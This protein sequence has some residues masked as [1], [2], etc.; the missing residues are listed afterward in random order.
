VNITSRRRLTITTDEKLERAREARAAA[1]ARRSAEVER[2]ELK[3]IRRVWD[4]IPA[5]K[6]RVF[7][8]IRKEIASGNRDAADVAALRETRRIHFAPYRRK[9]VTT[10]A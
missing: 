3:E 5:E 4:A 2:N 6:R 8:Y 9:E 1:A 7:D 10:D